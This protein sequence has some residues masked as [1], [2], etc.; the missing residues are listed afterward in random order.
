MKK[1]IFAV[2]FVLSVCIVG[3]LVALSYIQE[4]A[5]ESAEHERPCDS[6]QIVKWTSVI[7]KEGKYQLGKLYSRG[8]C[9]DQNISR[10]KELYATVYSD[11]SIKIARAL[12]HDAIQLADFGVRNPQVRN[13]ENVRLLLEE[14]KKIGIPAFG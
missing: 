12:F 3:F 10:A 6:Y 5:R 7:S 14:S 13:P 9:F 8:V 1:L 2:L 11:N 4:A